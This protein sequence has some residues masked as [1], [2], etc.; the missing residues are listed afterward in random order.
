MQVA[1][2]FGKKYWRVFTAIHKKRYIPVFVGQG[3][4]IMVWPHSCSIPLTYNSN[5]WTE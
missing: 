4:G 2:F 5:G 3:W 1:F